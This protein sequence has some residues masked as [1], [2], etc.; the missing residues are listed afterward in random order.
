[1]DLHLKGK[2]ALVTGGSEGI[3]EGIVLELAKEGVSVAVCARREEPLMKLA[4][5]LDEIG[6]PYFTVSADCTSQ[7]QM[8]DVVASIA[9]KLGKIDILVNNAGGGASGER[10]IE[11]S[12]EA[13]L[14]CYDLN[15]WSTVRTTRAV[16]PHMKE[17]K[18]GN[19][20]I[21][22]S[23]GGHS[24]GMLGVADYNSAKAA[25]L[26]LTKSWAH[27]FAPDKVRVN[28]ICPAFIRTPLWE[29]LALAFTPGEGETTETFFEKT[30]KEL[31][32]R[33]MGKPEDV[34]RVAAFLASDFAA[35][36]ITGGCWDVDGGF[37]TK[38]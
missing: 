26:L 28:A 22:S 13:W 9:E 35:G 2:V 24:G 27:D 36:F 15:V 32:V 14:A 34:G 23:V 20:I 17:R 1:M 8:N 11:D 30:A 19:V 29:K 25:Q 38:I 33:R 21:V 10:K 6:N 18:S 31:P 37:T 5:K 16:Y 12:D 4:K 3:G 7:S